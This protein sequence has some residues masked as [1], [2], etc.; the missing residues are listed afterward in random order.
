MEFK[1]KL[2]NK[3]GGWN[4]MACINNSTEYLLGVTSD[5]LRAVQ[6]GKAWK[7]KAEKK[8]REDCKIY[9]GLDEDD[10]NATLN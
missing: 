9:L 6:I 1:Y 3:L 7:Q 8:Y 10:S 2:R 4:V 5:Y